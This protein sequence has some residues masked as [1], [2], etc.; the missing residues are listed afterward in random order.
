MDDSS[1]QFKGV[2]IVDSY[3]DSE[4]NKN[5]N[6]TGN[7]GY[8]HS[9]DFE[10]NKLYHKYNDGDELTMG[11]VICVNIF[12]YQSERKTNIIEANTLKNIKIWDFHTSELLQIIKTEMQELY[13]LLF[14]EKYLLYREKTNIKVYDLSLNKICNYSLYNDKQKEIFNIKIINSPLNEK[15]LLIFEKYSIKIF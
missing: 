8:C 6:I 12:I 11:I 13:I 4:L 7:C 3:F 9:F 15:F 14:N 5:Y 1:G 2:S 10:K